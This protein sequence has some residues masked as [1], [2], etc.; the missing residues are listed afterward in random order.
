MSAIW[1][2][3]IYIEALMKIQYSLDVPIPKGQSQYGKRP[4]L[5][6]LMVAGAGATASLRK[7]WV[8]RQEANSIFFSY[9]FTEDRENISFGT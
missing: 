7:R 6:K 2:L 9:I 8:I 5:M 1:S 4:F 3:F